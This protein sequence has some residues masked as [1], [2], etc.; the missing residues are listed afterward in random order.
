M[1]NYEWGSYAPRFG[2]YGL[3]RR[4]SGP[5]RWL[6]TDAAGHPSAAAFARIIAGLRRGDASVL[7][8]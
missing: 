5:P 8:R 2:L 7:D 4:P 3:D 6:D 1:D